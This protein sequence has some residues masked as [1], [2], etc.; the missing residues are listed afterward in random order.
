M[1]HLHQVAVFYLKIPY[2]NSVKLVIL[3]KKERLTFKYSLHKFFPV[4]I[5]ILLKSSNFGPLPRGGLLHGESKGKSAVA[6]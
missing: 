2:S 3:G 5:L 6:R 4:G 1:I